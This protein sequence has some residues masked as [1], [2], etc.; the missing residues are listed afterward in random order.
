[1]NVELFAKLQCS[2]ESLKKFDIQAKDKRELISIINECIFKKCA[3]NS[4]E[5]YEVLDLRDKVL[6][7]IRY[8]IGLIKWSATTSFAQGSNST[9]QRQPIIQNDLNGTCQD[10]CPEKERYSR[11]YLSLSHK[12]E[13]LYDEQE[14]K[15]VVDHNLM[16]KEYSRSSADQ[17][18]PLP[19]EMRPLPVLYDTMN[20]LIND[21]IPQLI[22]FDS[23]NDQ[24]IGFW[25]DFVWNRTRAIR[26]DIIQQRLLLN[27]EPSPP[28]NESI[29]I[30]E[31][32]DD[33]QLVSGV[34][35]IEQ[36]ARFHVMCA[37][38]LCLQSPEVFDFKINEE[39]LKNC[40]QSLQIG[41]AHV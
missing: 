27:N 30:R 7:L 31:Y 6:K 40:F 13:M 33:N 21:I 12:Y 37:Y 32:E 26:K 28:S 18:W 9:K 23:V 19:S 38:R 4:K 5:R 29:D 24:S 41:R 36:C 25:Y 2:D 22:D 14:N 11:D 20:Y 15:D 16:I 39:N 8:E 35:I 34:G 3:K 10:M 1:M 17:D